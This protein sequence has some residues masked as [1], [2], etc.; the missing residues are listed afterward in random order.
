MTRVGLASDF[1]L[2]LE[3]LHHFHWITTD[4][5][6]CSS[7]LLL[8]KRA[9]P[10]GPECVRILITGAVLGLKLIASTR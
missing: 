10:R 1:V 2:R 4:T 7:G 5:L 3:L 9:D 8:Y 6:V